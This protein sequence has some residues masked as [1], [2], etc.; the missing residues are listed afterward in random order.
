MKE[1]CEYIYRLEQVDLPSADDYT[2]A[3]MAGPYI[4]GPLDEDIFY[5]MNVAHCRKNK[6][7]EFVKINIRQ[8]SPE[9]IS[10]KHF[11]GCPSLRH[12]RIWFRGFL[13][14]MLGTGRVH[15]AEYKV[16][17]AIYGQKT[18]MQAAFAVEDIISKRI[19]KL[20]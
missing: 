11:C 7:G 18:R 6:L 16:K 13:P 20:K 5:E 8:D 19:I 3:V 10:E 14:S 4:Q 2:G 9:F 1:D 15:I 17:K 12:L